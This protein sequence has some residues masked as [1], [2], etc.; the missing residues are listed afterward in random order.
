MDL[1][2][3]INKIK[4]E[5]RELKERMR[6]LGEIGKLHSKERKSNAIDKVFDIEQDKLTV[7]RFIGKKTK[8][9]IQN[10]SLLA[11]YGYKKEMGVDKVL[12]SEIK[13]NVAIN[14]VPVENFG[15]YIKKIIPK[16]I[17][18]IGK[19]FSTKYQYKLTS[20]GEVKAKEILEETIKG[21][22]NGKEKK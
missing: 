6:K 1:E 7:I 17:L 14:K 4:D 10:I 21:E 19:K 11:L 15:T 18:G 13:R 3:E 2:K 12:S 5:I 8:E 16:C 9:K 20:Y 22:D